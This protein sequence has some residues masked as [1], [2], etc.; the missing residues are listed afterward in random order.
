MS[1]RRLLALTALAAAAVPAAALGAPSRT[2]VACTAHFAHQPGIA[3]KSVSFK[4]TATGHAAS[5]ALSCARGKA[6]IML[7]CSFTTDGDG[8]VYDVSGIPHDVLPPDEIPEVLSA[9]R[10]A[11]EEER[12]EDADRYVAI[13]AAALQEYAKRLDS[14]VQLINSPSATAQR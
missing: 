13:T 8:Y 3:T 7:T 4:V 14:A 1:S 9:V 2:T 11:I 12:W 5:G 10:E 6:V